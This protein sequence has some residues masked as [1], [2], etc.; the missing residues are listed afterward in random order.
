MQWPFKAKTRC[1]C[2]HCVLRLYVV[3]GQSYMLAAGQG[4]RGDPDELSR[5]LLSVH[6]WGRLRWV[7]SYYYIYY[8]LHLH[9]V[10]KKPLFQVFTFQ[11]IIQNI[12]HYQFLC[13]VWIC[14][15]I[16]LLFVYF[17]YLDVMSFLLIHSKLFTFMHDQLIFCIYII[18]FCANRIGE[19]ES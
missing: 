6:E 16:S 15:F 5:T 2:S 12:E 19:G 4:R 17:F 13:N 9:I 11:N 7:L 14:C 10:A 1:L 8:K 18:F 3:L